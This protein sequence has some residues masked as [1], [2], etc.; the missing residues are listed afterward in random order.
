MA[1]EWGCLRVPPLLQVWGGDGSGPCSG[2]TWMPSHL[3]APR[4]QFTF[5]GDWAFSQGLFPPKKLRLPYCKSSKLIVFGHAVPSLSHLPVP[6]KDV[7]V[8]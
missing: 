6:G 7:A 3:Q 4:L 1:G 2:P 5:L 8:S